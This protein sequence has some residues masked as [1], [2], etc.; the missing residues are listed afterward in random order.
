MALLYNLARM[1]TATT[2]TGT[3]TLGSAVDGFLSF[4]AAGVSDADVVS[5]A[6]QDGSNSE[7][8]TGTYTAS[9]TT[10]TRT[11]LKSTNSDAAI[12][13]S[14]NAEVFITPS[15]ES[16]DHGNLTG[17]TDDDH[18]QYHNN[19]RGDARYLLQGDTPY[20][21]LDEGT[22]S[23]ATSTTIDLPSGYDGI[24]VEII[25]WTPSVAAQ[26]WVQF[27]VD[28]GSSWISSNYHWV[29]R[30]A[31]TDNT[32]DNANATSATYIQ[33]TGTQANTDGLFARIELPQYQVDG[34]KR[35]YYKSLYGSSHPFTL[36]DGIGFCTNTSLTSTAID[37][38]RI[39]PDPTSTP[40][41][42][43]KY[44]VRGWSSAGATP[45]VFP[46]LQQV[47]GTIR[48]TGSGWDVLDDSTHESIGVASVSEDTSKITIT[49]DF[50]ATKV[51]SFVATPDE[52]Y[53]GSDIS[54]IGA[55]VAVTYAEL[56]LTNAAG[57]AVD[58]TSL[59]NG[60][61]NIWF[62]GLFYR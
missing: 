37:A 28:G 13:L 16:F 31:Q 4:S 30:Y 35:I 24:V 5:Y 1:T 58:P 41:A 61:G 36:I 6:I 56:Y 46:K 22:V 12:S 45:T 62:Q 23:A 39:Y 25:D 8:G 52:T 43:W 26:M 19:T 14:G 44:Q 49:F 7:I 50:T 51:V 40:T 60:S 59:T 21:L 10:L 32:V 2:G 47:A 34:P 54:S 55:S 11:V 3:I 42:T 27:S 38:L 20:V 48:N 29:W 17:L 9:G 18:T 53:T 57:S 15:T 33:M